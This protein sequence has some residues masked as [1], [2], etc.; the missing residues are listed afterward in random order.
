MLD[1]MWYPVMKLCSYPLKKLFA[2]Q[3][4]V[5]ALDPQTL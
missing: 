4:F 5:V 2:Y 1:L 3:R